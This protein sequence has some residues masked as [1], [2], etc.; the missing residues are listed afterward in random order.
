MPKA[1]R[2]LFVLSIDTEEEWDWSGDFPQSDCSLSNIGE[3]PR[4][5]EFCDQHGVHTTYLI[6]YAVAA[7]QDSSAV[8]RRVARQ[9]NVEVGAHLHPWCNPPFYGPTYERESHVVNLPI[10]HVESKLINLDQVI[11]Q[12]VGVKATCFRTGRWGINSHIMKLLVKHGYKVDSS[13]YPYYS[14]QFFSCHGSPNTPYWADLEAPLEKTWEKQ[15]FEFPVTAGFNRK[16]FELWDRMHRI[17]STKP[18][19][20]LRIIGVLWR[21]ELLRKIYFSPELSRL[22]DMLS[23]AETSI[24]RGANTL[25]MY[26]HSP[27]LKAGCSPFVKTDRDVSE[28]YSRMDILFKTLKSKYDLEFCTLSAASKIIQNN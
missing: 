24:Q 18:I 6:D 25:H 10:S 28:L 19:S 7:D 20:F 14:N 12:N 3:I 21:T 23:L 16:N 9:D 17:A 8:I 26:L 15:L 1:K 27:S 4:F 2:I 13:V 22:D 5:Q 11:R